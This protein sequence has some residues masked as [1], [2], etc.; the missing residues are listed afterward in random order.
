MVTKVLAMFKEFPFMALGINAFKYD[1]KLASGISTYVCDLPVKM[2][3]KNKM[4]RNVIFCNVLMAFVLLGHLI[5]GM[6]K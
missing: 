6:C 2:N 1:A 4:L 3:V 5:T